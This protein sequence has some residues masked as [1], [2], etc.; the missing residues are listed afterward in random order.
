MII[1]WLENQEKKTKNVKYV[2][3]IRVNVS[4]NG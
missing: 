2:T 1:A 3:W 4:T